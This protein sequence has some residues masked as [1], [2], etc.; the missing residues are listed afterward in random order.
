MLRQHGYGIGSSGSSGIKKIEAVPRTNDFSE[1]SQREHAIDGNRILS[2]FHKQS[3]S[4]RRS[5]LVRTLYVLYTIIP[6][7]GINSPVLSNR[8]ALCAPL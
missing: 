3:L 5:A 4:G 1:N 6:Y 8:T 7:N 2:D